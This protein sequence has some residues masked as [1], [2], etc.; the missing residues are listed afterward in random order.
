MTS[1]A[2]EKQDE[3]LEAVVLWALEVGASVEGS[4]H[5]TETQDFSHTSESNW[6]DNRSPK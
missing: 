4:L 2:E 6:K 1:S 5:S 3:I